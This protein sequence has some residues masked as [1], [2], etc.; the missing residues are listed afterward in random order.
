MKKEQQ[1]SSIQKPTKTKKKEVITRNSRLTVVFNRIKMFRQ[2]FPD[3]HLFFTAISKKPN[4]PAVCFFTNEETEEACMKGRKGH[5]DNV[6][7]MMLCMESELKNTKV[8]K[9]NK[10]KEQFKHFFDRMMTYASETSDYVKAIICPT[11]TCAQT[12]T[13]I[14]QSNPNI[15]NFVEKEK[16]D[17][18]IYD[19]LNYD[20]F[21]IGMPTSIEE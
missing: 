16:P 19:A 10:L 1:I 14:W 9:I 20:D 8:K 13:F 18:I 11:N 5:I 15:K 21:P 2:S 12:S 4:L 3:Y 6:N 7:D 17:V